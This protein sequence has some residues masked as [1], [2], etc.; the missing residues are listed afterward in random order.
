MKKTVRVGTGFF[1]SVFNPSRG[2]GEVV[3]PVQPPVEVEPLPLIVPFGSVGQAPS[4]RIQFLCGTSGGKTSTLSDVDQ[5]THILCASSEKLYG[6]IGGCESFISSCS[7]TKYIINLSSYV[8]L[9]CPS[10]RFHPYFL[11]PIA[12]LSNFSSYTPLQP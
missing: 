11:S 5:R 6:L 10:P 8:S 4:H 1:P 7:A 3:V 12:V 2:C 9:L